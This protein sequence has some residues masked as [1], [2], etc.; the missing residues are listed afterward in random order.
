MKK[1]IILILSIFLGFYAQV[2]AQDPDCY[3]F[4]ESWHWRSNR[5]AKSR[6]W[7][8][9]AGDEDIFSFDP[10]SETWSS[11]N[12]FLEINQ[13]DTINFVTVD[14][15]N[16]VWYGLKDHRPRMFHGKV[17]YYE[18]LKTHPFLRIFYGLIPLDD[19]EF[20]AIGYSFNNYDVSAG[21]NTN[22]GPWKLCS[23]QMALTDI[24]LDSKGG[25]WTTTTYGLYMLN[26][27][28]V[29]TKSVT[30]YPENKIWHGGVS[31]LV[32]DQEDNI[33]MGSRTGLIHFDT[34]TKKFRE[35]NYLNNPEIP[36]GF[37][38]AS[39]K[40]E[41]HNLW[42]SCAD[43]LVKYDGNT[44]TSYSCPEYKEARSILC[45]KDIVWILTRDQTL[46][47]FD[48][49]EFKAF[50]LV[51]D[52]GITTTDADAVPFK[53]SQKAQEI[54]ISGEVSISGVALYNLSGTQLSSQSFAS[55]R[56]VRIEHDGLTDGI[57]LLKIR[58]E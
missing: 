21:I 41:K 37:Y 47:R 20:Y 58:H 31:T 7:L 56:A 3:R 19:D 9:I 15:K 55:E 51:K 22:F 34:E 36:K 28:D 12:L 13:H 23:N 18:D 52:T 53:V 46:L 24:A 54:H 29:T 8:W 25:V 39:D 4:E 48:N 6:E 14:A 44:F 40:D 2:L 32:I 50:Q 43:H 5:L 16:R 49:G 27:V 33:W 35:F 11:M 42:F 17:H 38:S 30:T 10:T 57:Y 45:D 1:T 26:H